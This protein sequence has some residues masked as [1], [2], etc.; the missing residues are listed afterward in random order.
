MADLSKLRDR[1]NMKLA[2]PEYEPYI[3]HLDKYVLSKLKQ[4]NK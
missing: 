1:L 4:S 3:D 2:K